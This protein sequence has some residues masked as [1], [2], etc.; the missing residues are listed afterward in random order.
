M[1]ML[2]GGGGGVAAVLLHERKGL[3]CVTRQCPPAQG[4]AMGTLVIW[5]CRR[6]AVLWARAHPFGK[7]LG[8][9]GHLQ[10][11]GGDPVR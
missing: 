4:L 8:F 11:W 2:G 5:S 10:L 1:G 9:L 3:R 6:F 7:G